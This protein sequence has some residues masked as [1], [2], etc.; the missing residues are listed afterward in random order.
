MSLTSKLSRDLA[1]IPAYGE[2]GTKLLPTVLVLRWSEIALP[3][4]LA[5]EFGFHEGPTLSHLINRFGLG[6]GAFSPDWNS[7]DFEAAL[8]FVLRFTKVKQGNIQSLPVL[9][10]SWPVI[11]RP[12][13]IPWGVRTRSCLE[14]AGLLD[15][16]E[17]LGWL[18]FGDFFAI[19][20]MGV[21]SILEF[22]V[23]LEQAMDIAKGF[24][25]KQSTAIPSLSSTTE[26]STSNNPT[27]TREIANV[28]QKSF[29]TP[30]EQ[31]DLSVRATNCL[32]GGNILTLRDLLTKTA[33]DLYRLDNFGKKSLV[34]VEDFLALH[35]FSLG[36]VPE[37]LKGDQSSSPEKSEHDLL[38]ENINQEA[39]R[40]DLIALEHIIQQPWAEQIFGSDPR[41]SDLLPFRTDSV[42]QIIDGLLSAWNLNELT[43]K[44]QRRFHF[45]SLEMDNLTQRVAEIGQLTLDEALDQLFEKITGQKGSRK[46]VLMLRMGW[47][48][49]S[50]ITLQD[51]GNLLGLTRERVRQIQERLTKKI[52]SL[53]PSQKIFLPQIE[54]AIDVLDRSLPLTTAE[55]S[56]LLQDKGITRELFSIR[57]IQFVCEWLH[58]DCPF[59]IVN[60]GQSHGNKRILV[61]THG[62]T[63]VRL[64]L[65]VARRLA[66][67]S[68]IANIY[69]VVERAAPDGEDIDPNEAASV[70]NQVSSSIEF[71][72]DDWF[73]MTNIPIDR[74]RL[75]NT[76]RRMLSVVSS[77]SLKEIRAGLRRHYSLRASTNKRYSE[78]GRSPIRVP[79]LD[80]LR[81]FFEKH[82]EF[83]VDEQ[84]LVH[85]VSFLDYREE[86]GDTERVMVDVLRSSPSGLL[87]RY[88]FHTQCVSRGMNPTTFD[89]Y[90][91]F[92]PIISH[93]DLNVWGLR[94]ADVNPAA[95]VAVREANAQ[96]PTEQRVQDFGWSDEGNI[97]LKVRLPQNVQSFVFGCPSDISRFILEREF[98]A[99][100][101]GEQRCGI[102][103]SSSSSLYGFSPFLRKTGA[104]EGDIL[105][106]VFN[107]EKNEAYLS[108]APEDSLVYEI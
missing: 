107:I 12:D 48:P 22:A 101:D 82:P 93:L 71:L 41:F 66:G 74:N 13:D 19:P 108:L 106:I 18:T 97:W 58:H 76:C 51:A 64:L 32:L 80:V 92:S 67:V 49:A 5:A 61:S 31:C 103:K 87:D 90:T 20:S 35:G 39:L 47:A 30:I 85:T 6:F 91:S 98:A 94:G 37:D 16:Y 21:R 26:S 68:G 10:R 42:Y 70:L 33:A 38:E 99:F 25:S 104:D 89:L 63:N 36:R 95:I 52:N 27:A 14:K 4:R 100:G 81:R 56:R 2:P 15:H 73:W 75:R 88:T 53:L 23:I 69:D 9:P 62:S 17:K 24:Y 43:V 84:D 7:K 34:E 86:L 102:I 96:R 40:Q 54:Q 59:S 55:A 28:L 1:E 29:D 72:S 11:L 3:E 83:S 77:I 57:N 65:R 46:S 79:P 45:L 105:E 60:S 78:T 50:A 8:N 44:D